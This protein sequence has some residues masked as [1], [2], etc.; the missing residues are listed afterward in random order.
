M[1]IPKKVAEAQAHLRALHVEVLKSVSKAES[2]LKKI[3]LASEMGIIVFSDVCFMAAGLHPYPEGFEP[4][5]RKYDLGGFDNDIKRARR[6]EMC[7]FIDG[8]IQYHIN[9]MAFS[10]P[11]NKAEAERAESWVTFLNQLLELDK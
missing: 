4:A 10:K 5:R 8:C 6:D 3:S 9:Q 7:R 1:T 2:Q 11:A